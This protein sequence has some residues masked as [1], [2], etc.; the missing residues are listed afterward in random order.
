[1][2]ESGRCWGR[3]LLEAA[4]VSPTGR[5]E[6]RFGDLIFTGSNIVL[7]MGRPDSEGRRG[8]RRG[9]GPPADSQQGKEGLRS[10]GTRNRILLQA[11]KWVLPESLQGRPQPRWCWAWPRETLS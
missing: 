8:P 9:D 10:T 4:W 11:W 1:M 2:N 6:L 5:Q 3:W 7:K